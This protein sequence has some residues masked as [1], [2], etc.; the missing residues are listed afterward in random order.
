MIGKDAFIS[1]LEE[2]DNAIL[3]AL[4]DPG[5]CSFHFSNRFEQRMRSVIR[6]GNHP[7]MYKTLQRVACVLLALLM[8]FSSV[9]IFNTDARASVIGWI[10]EQYESF[11]HYF[12]PAETTATEQVQYTLGWVPDGY[13]LI[14]TQ[15]TELRITQIYFGPSNQMIQ[16]T[17]Q[18]GT[19]ASYAFFDAEAFTQH[20]VIV[21]SLNAEIYIS[22]TQESTNSIVWSDPSRGVLFSISAPLTETELI[23]IAENITNQ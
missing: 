1:A 10:K 4:P 19:N 12:F 20:S 7:T 17:Y 11:Y 9:M 2:I 6:R 15:T 5:D 18:Q 16:F 8:L 22:T 14:N 13:T 3:A 23:K 21:G